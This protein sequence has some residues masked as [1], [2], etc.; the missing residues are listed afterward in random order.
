MDIFRKII[1]SG[2]NGFS[3][4]DARS[5]IRNSEEVSRYVNDKKEH[6][7]YVEQLMHDDIIDSAMNRVKQKGDFVYNEEG[8]EYRPNH[9]YNRQSGVLLEES[10][11]YQC[12]YRPIQQNSVEARLEAMEREMRN[13]KEENARLR[14]QYRTLK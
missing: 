13:L 3:T 1:E 11:T 12:R 14:N 8:V 6:L 4:N 10:P 5:I 9:N 7:R 2:F